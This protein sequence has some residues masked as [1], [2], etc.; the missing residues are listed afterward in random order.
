MLYILFH[1]LWDLI[2][3]SDPSE[4]ANLTI[5]HINA[6]S[7]TITWDTPIVPSGFITGYIIR[8]DI[9]PSGSTDVRSTIMSFTFLGLIPYTNYTFA[10]AARTRQYTGLNA[11]VT[12]TTSQAGTLFYILTVDKF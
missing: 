3:F 7:A 12:V 1:F 9:F 5:S 2:F 8:S 4:P 10:V 6:T 11:S